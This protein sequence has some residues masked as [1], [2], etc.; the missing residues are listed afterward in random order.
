MDI[1]NLISH[2]VKEASEK[3]SQVNFDNDVINPISDIN[4]V[5]PPAPEL[6]DI[7]KDFKEI[8]GQACLY[9]MDSC[10]KSTM[11]RDP[12]RHD[13]S[14]YRMSSTEKKAIP[15]PMGIHNLSE[16]EKEES[17]KE[18][19]KNK[20]NFDMYDDSNDRIYGRFRNF[21]DALYG[22]WVYLDPA[23]QQTIMNSE[24]KLFQ[25]SI[26]HSQPEYLSGGDSMGSSDSSGESIS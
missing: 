1:E 25:E 8:P 17:Q 5:L 7:D 6:N 19:H 15:Y 18:D 4:W 3:L 14:L 12:Q 2:I 10:T 21:Y 23:T 13:T 26:D 11:N 22:P 24:N 9:N 20:F 16:I